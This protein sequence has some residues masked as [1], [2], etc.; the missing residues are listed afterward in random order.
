MVSGFNTNIRYRGR[1]FHVQTEDSGGAKPEITTLL[2]E[3]GA[4][5]CSRKQRYKQQ[6]GEE[7]F[8]MEVRTLMEGQHR[9]IVQALKSGEM[10]GSIGL[11]SAAGKASPSG[12]G[13]DAEFGEGIISDTPLDEVILAHL[14]NH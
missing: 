4:I 2:Y 12:G 10:D 6:T 11:P 8:E 13:S 3:G 5:L 14:G 7:D 1:T 9:G